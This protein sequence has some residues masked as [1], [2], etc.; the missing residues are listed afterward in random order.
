MSG[1]AIRE[2]L[3]ALGVIASMVFVG[4]E[5]RQNTSATR[6]ATQNAIHD[7]GRQ[8]VFAAMANIPLMD[9]MVAVENDPSLLDRLGGTLEGRL[10]ENFHNARFNSMENT[11]FHYREG[12]LDADMWVGWE[13]WISRH[14]NDDP[15]FR[16]FWG[17]LQTGYGGEFRGMIDSVLANPSPDDGTQ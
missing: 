8:G 17:V 16:H 7:A 12:T 4:W 2:T 13:G 15:A 14:A 3:A 9:V 1:K 11:Y 5:I 6:S 10:L